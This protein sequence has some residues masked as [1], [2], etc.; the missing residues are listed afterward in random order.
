MKPFFGSPEALF[1]TVA[2]VFYIALLA[3]PIIFACLAK[4]L[5]KR[6][7]CWVFY[8]AWRT[9]EYAA[10][11]IVCAIAAIA[12]SFTDHSPIWGVLAAISGAMSGAI[13]SCAGAVGLCRRRLYCVV[14]LIAPSAL[15]A[16]FG[17]AGMI[18]MLLSAQSRTPPAN[19]AFGMFFVFSLLFAPFTAINFFYF[20]KRWQDMQRGRQRSAL[21]NSPQTGG[22]RSS[23]GR[24]SP[25]SSDV[26]VQP[27]A[28]SH[29]FEGYRQDYRGL[30]H[31]FG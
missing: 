2:F 9:A 20:K 23:L 13:V 12:F 25:G 15:L 3:L 29:A 27:G 5:G 10:A 14:V 8:L 6:P 18:G 19:E 4:S 24:Q 16:L 7:Y 31:F 11:C 30:P 22:T 26:S 28:V 17:I 1:V 21:M